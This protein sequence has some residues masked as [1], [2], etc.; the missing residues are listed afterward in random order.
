MLSKIAGMNYGGKPGQKV[1]DATNNQLPALP[2]ALQES[3]SDYSDGESCP[4][5]PEFMNV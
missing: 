2:G 4:R 1:D 3:E 5:L